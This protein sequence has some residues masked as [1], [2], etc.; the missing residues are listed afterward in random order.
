MLSSERT[1]M[2][3]HKLRAEHA[4][5]LVGT[6]TALLDD[7]RL[8]V[9]RWAGPSPVRVVLD[10]DLALPPS[11]R[12]LDGSHPTLVFTGRADA[13]QRPG[14]EYVTVDYGRDVLPQ[15]LAGLHARGL[16][17]L[18]VEGGA[19][20]LQSFIDSGLW[21]EAYVEQSPLVLGAGVGAPLM[22]RGSVCECLSA[23]GRAYR[24]YGCR[25]T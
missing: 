10:R 22:P 7:P 23:F 5:I 11:A 6:R 20:L 2:L 9:R 1:Q 24:H 14:V 15:L 25:R 4:A 13:V 8:D 18:L 3:V 16:Q 21:D 19:R 17:S 12:L